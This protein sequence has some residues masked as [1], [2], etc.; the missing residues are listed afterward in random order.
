MDSF[1]R[2]HFSKAGR[3]LSR[4]LWGQRGD[5][6]CG[7]LSLLP[8]FGRGERTGWTEPPSP[9]PGPRVEPSRGCRGRE[10]S[11]EQRQVSLGPSLP[12]RAGQSWGRGHLWVAASPAFLRSALPQPSGLQK[13]GGA[14]TQA[15]PPRQGRALRP[16]APRTLWPEEKQTEPAGMALPWAINTQATSWAPV[17]D[18]RPLSPL[19]TAF[20]AVR[21]TCPLSFPAPS[22]R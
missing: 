5:G 22:F 4:A 3:R 19:I 18:G 9:G 20:R 12:L 15:G 16:A 2:V 17:P 11:G 8:G 13:V 14:K 21:L 7:G 10:A 1:S 6:N